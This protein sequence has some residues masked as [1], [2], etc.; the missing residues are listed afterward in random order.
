MH[1][2]SG[3]PA[4][5]GCASC[6]ACLLFLLRAISV[7]HV[8]PLAGEVF[9]REQDLIND[10]LYGLFVLVVQQLALGVEGLACGTQGMLFGSHPALKIEHQRG[11]V[12]K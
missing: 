1:Y 10:G 8:C 3:M 7:W 5:S 9:C 4:A 11:Q 2:A 12:A 6:T